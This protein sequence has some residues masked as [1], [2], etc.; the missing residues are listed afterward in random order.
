V[1]VGTTSTNV[2]EGSS[3]GGASSKDVG[4]S[5]E[6]GFG[7]CRGGVPP[8]LVTAGDPEPL[9]PRVQAKTAVEVRCPVTKTGS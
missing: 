7:M 1:L 5:G 8:E 9:M 6:F 4:L 3:G 2:S